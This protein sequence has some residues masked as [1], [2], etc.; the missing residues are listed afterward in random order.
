[1][2]FVD[3]IEELRWHIIRAILAILIASAYCFFNIEWIFTNIILGPTQNDFIS[4][5]YLNKLGELLHIDVLK[6]KDMSIQFQNTELSG[7]FMMSFSVSFMMGL[8]VA[9]PVV[10]WEL[11]KFIRPA[12]K[13]NELKYARGIVF[14]SSLLFFIGVLFAYYIIAPFTINFFANYQLSPQFKNII[15]ITNYYDTMSDL[16]MGMGLVF[17]LPVIVYFLSRIGILTPKLMRDKRRYAILIIFFLAVIISPP[18]WFSCWLIALPL[19]LL[20]EISIGISDRAN[21]ARMKKQLTESN[22]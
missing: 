3:H 14:W 20:F 17:E 11:W 10:F 22:L 19:M 15:T 16:I 6:L 7:Q 21:K 8:I 5:Q 4:Y 18:D 2:A 12:L 13:A 9:F 1:M